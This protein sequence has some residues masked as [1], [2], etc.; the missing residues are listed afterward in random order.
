MRNGDLSEINFQIFDPATTA[1]CATCS[2]GFSR[3]PFP[4]NIIPSSRFNS[5]TFALLNAYPAETSSGLF[6]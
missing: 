4:G 2:S 5:A 6:Q 3:Q 1:P